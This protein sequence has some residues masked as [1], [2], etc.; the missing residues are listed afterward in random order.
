M[1]IIER[2]L[3]HLESKNYAAVARDL[4]IPVE[5]V[6]KA[7]KVE[8]GETV[9]IFFKPKRQETEDYITGRFG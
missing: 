7:V 3:K 4:G 9:Q 2:H 8:F 1:A 6:V 5:Q